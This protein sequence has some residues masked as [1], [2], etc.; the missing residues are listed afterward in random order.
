[1][2]YLPIPSGRYENR[3]KRIFLLNSSAYVLSTSRTYCVKAQLSCTF[4][5]A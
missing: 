5:A 4:I 3:H 2:S 1:M